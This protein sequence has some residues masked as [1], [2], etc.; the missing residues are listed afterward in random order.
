METP[1][2]WRAE[3]M[4]A[5]ENVVHSLMKQIGRGEHTKPGGEDGSMR[6][7]GSQR[8]DIKIEAVSS[9]R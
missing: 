4:A 5:Q 8:G 2:E 3:D 7:S 6:Y 1:Q 9:R